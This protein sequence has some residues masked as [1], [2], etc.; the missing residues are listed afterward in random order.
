MASST[1]IWRQLF[2]LHSLAG[3]VTAIFLLLL[4]ISGSALVFMEE[5]DAMLNRDILRVE[6]KEQTLPLNKLYAI[7]T[8]QY[9]N[10]GGIGWTNPEAAPDEACNFRL[11]LNDGKVYTYDLAILTINPYTGALIRSGRYD[12]LHSGI[13]QWLFQFHFS[14]HLGMPG[15]LLTAILGITMLISCITGLMVY[16]K[17]LWKVITFRVRINWKNRRRLTSDL[18]R[19]IGVWAL[20]LNLIIFFTGFWMNL[21]AFQPESW[22]KKMVENPVH[23]SGLLPMDDLLK[24]AKH[25]M[26]QLAIEHIYMP[27]Q[28]G[29]LF[30]VSGSLPGDSKLFGNSS[31]AMNP[32]TGGIERKTIQQELSFSKKLEAA[33]Q[34]L[35]V[36]SYGGY[37]IKFLYILIGLT[38]GILSVTGY[39][40]YLKRTKGKVKKEAVAVPEQTKRRCH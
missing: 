8:S 38:P 18:H 9:P 4:G 13:M 11:Y 12:D 17:Q 24:V 14:F 7:A 28:E 20:L 33:I 37:P 16:R 39:L 15:A 23:S 19:I 22:K 5:I 29:Q 32:L 31:I 2:R 10:L 40:L 3:L 27:A 30:R 21:F 25:A 36:G 6:K 1:K 34:P 35:H 26:P